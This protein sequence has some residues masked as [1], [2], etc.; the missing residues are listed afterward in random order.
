V[1]REFHRVLKPGGKAYLLATL[2]RRQHYPPYDYFRFTE[3]GLE[4]LLKKVGY[5]NIEIAHSNGFFGT[6]GQYGYFFQRGL[7]APKPVEKALDLFFWAVWEP[8][9]YALDR[10]DNGYGRNFTHHFMVYT[11]K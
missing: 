7:G 9:C 5:R 3:H 4:Y 2:T 11:Q 1:L 10:L 6:I 8:V